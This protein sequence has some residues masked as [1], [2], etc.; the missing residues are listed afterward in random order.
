MC[1]FAYGPT[2]SGKTFTMQGPSFDCE[3]STELRGILPRTA[4]FIFDELT[5]LQGIGFNFKLFFAAMEVYN[6]NIF[7]L[8]NPKDKTPLQTY[9]LKNNNVNKD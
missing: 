9:S 6:E 5:R 2:G 7:D 1:L 3:R 4:D 8:L